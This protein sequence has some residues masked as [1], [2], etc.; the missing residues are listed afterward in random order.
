MTWSSAGIPS[1]ALRARGTACSAH[2]RIFFG[3]RSSVAGWTGTKDPERSS[4][5]S[6]ISLAGATISHSCTAS[7]FGLRLPVIRIR[8]PF[9]SLPLTHGWLNQVAR[10][11]SVSSPTRTPTIVSFPRRNGRGGLPITS[12]STVPV[13]PAPSASSSRICRSRWECG[14]R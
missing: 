4:P 11:E 6:S 5:D 1:I 9:S 2:S 7:P 14:K 10:T 12:T 13:S 8:D 3:A